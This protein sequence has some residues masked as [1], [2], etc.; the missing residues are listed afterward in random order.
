M[1]FRS[2]ITGS[3]SGIGKAT[4]EVLAESG[5]GVYAGIRSMQHAE[6]FS[7]KNNII[8]IVLDVTDPN[9]VLAAF[10]EIQKRG[11]GL[12]GLVNNA[13]IA[14]AGALMDISDEDMKEQFEVNLFGVHRVTRLFIPLLHESQGRIVMMSSDSGFFATPFFGP[15]CSS[16]FA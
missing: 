10:K 16:K 14:K 1:L 7:S 3:S 15:Y 12:F 2:L 8:P 13:G 11:T 4:A 5:F 9:V 6:Q